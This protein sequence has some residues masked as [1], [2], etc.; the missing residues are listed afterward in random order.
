M[1]SEDKSPLEIFQPLWTD[2]SAIRGITTNQVLDELADM[3]EG[4][5]ELFATLLSA[6]KRIAR[7]W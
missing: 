7:E 4:A 6:V 2:D 3:A 1:A 5:P